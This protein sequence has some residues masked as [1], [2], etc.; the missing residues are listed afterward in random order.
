MFHHASP[1][2]GVLSFM[3]TRFSLLCA[4]IASIFLDKLFWKCIFFYWGQKDFVYVAIF[5]GGGDSG[6]IKRDTWKNI[7]VL[8]Y[9]VNSKCSL[10]FIAG[11]PCTDHHFRD[12]ED[13]KINRI[14]SHGSDLTLHKKIAYEFID[15]IFFFPGPPIL[16]M[17]SV[18]PV[19][20]SL[21]LYF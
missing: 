21:S 17:S 8:H 1:A 7:C 12:W 9:K 13:I 15:R 11:L 19:H 4:L 20:T 2:N 6:K 16:H 10:Q 3:S 14:W 18:F 5:V